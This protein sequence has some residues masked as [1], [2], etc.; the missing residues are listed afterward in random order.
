MSAG[1]E[2]A[3][4]QDGLQPNDQWGAKDSFCTLQTV[5]WKRPQ[6]A[7]TVSF[8]RRLDLLLRTAHV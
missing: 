4:E 2:S 1:V 6:V 7:S 3:E 8:I 5:Q